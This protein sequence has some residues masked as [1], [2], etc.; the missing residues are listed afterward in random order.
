MS[1]ETLK[2]G[3]K[4]SIAISDW[5]TFQYGLTYVQS[6]TFAIIR[7]QTERHGHFEGPLSV[8]SFWTGTTTKAVR[9]YLSVLETKGLITID[10]CE[11]KDH[12]HIYTCTAKLLFSK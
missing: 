11:V 8:I 1:D 3:I 4:K 7:Q 6:A 10:K 2:P 9:K 5:P 12:K